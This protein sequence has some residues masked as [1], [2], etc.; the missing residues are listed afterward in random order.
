MNWSRKKVLVTGA[1]GFIGSHLVQFL[2]ELGA[3]VRVFVRYT[4]S[5]NVGNL[6]FLSQCDELDFF[7]GDLKDPYAVRKALKDI[8]YVFHLAAL[9]SIPYS[10]LNPREYF[11]NNVKF[12]L[13][14]LQ[15][16]EDIGTEFVVHTSTSEVYGTAQYVPIDEK[17]PLTGQSP[18]SA[19]KIAAD[20]VVESFY[21]SYDSPVAILRPFNN[22]G[23]R[24][25]FRAVIPTIIGQLLRGHDLRLGDISTTRDFLYVKD[26]VRGFTRM[27]EKREITQGKT[28]NIGTGREVSIERVANY[29][30][31]E[32]NDKATIL[33]D[34]TKLR[35]KKSEVRRLCADISLAKEILDWKPVYSLE[36][37]LKETIA[38]IKENFSL[39]TQDSDFK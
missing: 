10:Y 9:I 6:K 21:L 5:G 25:S 29:L 15:A 24:Q 20:K 23:P 39:Y 38:W 22:F 28:I 12:I 30:I 8:D 2:M 14:I 36:Q 27:V 35:P 32:I 31:A 7:Y 1:G 3:D 11:E 17:H 16:I 19:S 37:G 26:T 34:S 4:S 18:Y 33:L 13:N